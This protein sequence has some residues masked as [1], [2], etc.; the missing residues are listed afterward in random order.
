MTQRS[1]VQ[2]EHKPGK[3][4]FVV[5]CRIQNTTEVFGHAPTPTQ[6]TTQERHTPTTLI[7]R[8]CKETSLFSFHWIVNFISPN[9]QTNLITSANTFRRGNSVLYIGCP[10]THVNPQYILG[11]SSSTIF[12]VSVFCSQLYWN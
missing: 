5:A 6:N 4:R 10:N 7:A 2:I 12:T 11:T 1:P 9:V 3:L 8:N